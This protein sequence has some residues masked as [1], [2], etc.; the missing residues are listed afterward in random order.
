M[1]ISVVGSSYA[2]RMSLSLADASNLSVDKVDLGVQIGT[3]GN[4]GLGVF[5]RIDADSNSGGSDINTRLINGLPIGTPINLLVR[6]VDFNENLTDYSSSYEILV[7][8]A[9]VNSGCLS[10]QRFCHRPLSYL[11]CGRPRRPGLLRQPATDRYG[12]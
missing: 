10:L 2:Q 7:N 9:V 3:D 12:R 1:D 4:G 6:V 11:R 8:G 5:K